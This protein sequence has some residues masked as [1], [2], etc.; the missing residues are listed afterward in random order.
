M[1]F[2]ARVNG[3]PA[4]THLTAVSKFTGIPER[5]VLLVNWK[6]EAFQPAHYLAIDRGAGRIVIAIRWV[7]IRA[8]SCGLQ[9][10]ILPP[11]SAICWNLDPTS[12]QQ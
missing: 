1:N 8:A 7:M 6:S 2:H 11:S 12:L 5:D 9:G 3:G 10:R 4:Q